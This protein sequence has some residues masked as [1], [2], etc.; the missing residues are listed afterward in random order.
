MAF[1]AAASE[2]PSFFTSSRHLELSVFFILAILI[3]VHERCGPE[4]LT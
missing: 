4:L 1:A 2:G 3:G